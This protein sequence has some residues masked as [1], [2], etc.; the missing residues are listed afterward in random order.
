MQKKRLGVST[1]EQQYLAICGMP[2][3]SFLLL[4]F[5]TP[6]LLLLIFYHEVC[7]LLIKGKVCILKNNS[8]IHFP[9]DQCLYEVKLIWQLDG[10]STFYCLV[11][12]EREGEKEGG[13]EEG[14]DR[15]GVLLLAAGKLLIVGTVQSSEIRLP[16]QQ[17]AF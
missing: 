1:A 5:L 2:Y 7:I 9:P 10:K 6:C 12:C 14:E 16:R 4:L 15:S 3:T 13:E 17:N 11:F 8:L